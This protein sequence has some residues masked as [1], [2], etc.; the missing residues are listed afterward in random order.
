MCMAK[1]VVTQR[2]GTEITSTICMMGICITQK[3]TR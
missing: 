3:A 1:I 2:L